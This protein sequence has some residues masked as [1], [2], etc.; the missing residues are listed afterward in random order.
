M[1]EIASDI[2]RIKIPLPT[3]KYLNSY[4]IRGKNRHLVVD[5]GLDLPECLEV[6]KTAL[7]RLGIVLKNADFFITH[8][9]GDHAGLI[10]RLAAKESRIYFNE[11]ESQLIGSYNFFEHLIG[12]N[13]KNGFPD[14]RLQ[15]MA[16]RAS[17]H[18]Q[19]YAWKNGLKIVKEQLRGH[20]LTACC[21]NWF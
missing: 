12:Y 16:K 1:E 10:V 13:R 2:F 15:A 7:D 3:F 4:V 9:H 6:M 21:S 5:T 17:N 20:I 18:I 14:N 8:F 19:D 11:P